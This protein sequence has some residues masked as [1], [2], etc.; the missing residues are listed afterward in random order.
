MYLLV[1]SLSPPRQLLTSSA[2][3]FSDS[4]L[5]LAGLKDDAISSCQ[6]VVLRALAAGARSS[7]STAV[8]LTVR[9]LPFMASFE[10][11]AAAG[12]AVG[13]RATQLLAVLEPLA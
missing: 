12:G 6:A 11:A 9:D 10:E 8:I 13:V 7:P 1:M 2:S 5:A 4:W 3:A